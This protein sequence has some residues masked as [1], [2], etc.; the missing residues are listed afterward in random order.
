MVT[1]NVTQR[2]MPQPLGTR[3]TPRSQS[4]ASRFPRSHSPHIFSSLA[5]S[6]IVAQLPSMPIVRP[7]PAPPLKTIIPARPSAQPNKRR[8]N[9]RSH[10]RQEGK[11]QRKTDETGLQFRWYDIYFFLG[12]RILVV[13][14]LNFFEK[15]E[16]EWKER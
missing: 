6:T 16:E 7:P 5:E 13:Y 12:G 9:Q 1:G 15:L 2:R 8:V 14:D 4:R 3:K 10:V 11:I